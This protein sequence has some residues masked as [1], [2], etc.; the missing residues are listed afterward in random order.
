MSRAAVLLGGI[1]WDGMEEVETSEANV[2][3]GEQAYPWLLGEGDGTARERY[4]DLGFNPPGRICFFFS[5]RGTSFLDAKGGAGSG[6]VLLLV[7]GSSRWDE[8]IR[9]MIHG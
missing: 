7:R 6:R 8:G 5:G 3:G 2:R 1:A 4:A 9:R